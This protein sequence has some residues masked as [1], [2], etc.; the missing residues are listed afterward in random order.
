MKQIDERNW[1][2]PTPERRRELLEQYFNEGHFC[3]TEEHYTT[4]E[5]V[6]TAKAHGWPPAHHDTA[7]A[8]E[9]KSFCQ[10]GAAG[11]TVPGWRES[12]E[13]IRRHREQHGLDWQVFVPHGKHVAPHLR[14]HEVFLAL[15]I[16]AQDQGEGGWQAFCDCETMPER[17]YASYED[18]VDAAVNH[19]V[20][21]DGRWAE[22]QPR[23][24]EDYEPKF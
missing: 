17:Y 11:E 19:A 10:C 9:Y 6:E 15:D 8:D 20:E 23:A 2:P 1:T 24:E 21:H 3:M 14:D 7:P 12:R 22:G 5:M 4:P 16:V 13:W 18:A